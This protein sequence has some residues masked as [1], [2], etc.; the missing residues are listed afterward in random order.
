MRKKSWAI[1]FLSIFA[2]SILV[3]IGMVSAMTPGEFFKTIF[4][5]G[6]NGGLNFA[7][8]TAQWYVLILVIILIY[9]SLS[10]ANF[11]DSPVLRWPIS[12]I[13]GLLATM[14][15]TTPEILAA[16]Q[17]YKALGITFLLFVP[18]IILTFFTFAVASKVNPFGIIVQR[19]AWLIYSVYLFIK[20]GTMLLLKWYASKAGANLSGLVKEGTFTHQLVTFFLGEDFAKTA[21]AGGD[22][23]IL[24]ILFIVSIAVFWIF[25]LGNKKV[26]EWFVRERRS[27]DITKYQDTAERAKAARETD[28]E[29][30]R[31]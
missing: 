13:V 17:S 2:I 8:A 12:I 1:L 14:L 22:T 31:T 3:N 18:I 28:A 19:I 16:L 7:G 21:L 15:I 23:L 26:T 20:T 30:T 25:V 5:V 27:A 11:P 4:F 29:A 24:V 10:Y 9:A 6:D